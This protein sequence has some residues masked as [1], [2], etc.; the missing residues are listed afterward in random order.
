[1]SMTTTNKTPLTC[2][3][4][5]RGRL[6]PGENLAG[7]AR[8]HYKSVHPRAGHIPRVPFGDVRRGLRRVPDH[9]GHGRDQRGDEHDGAGAVTAP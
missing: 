3:V 9:G 1:M 8:Q 4:R 7:R 5:C 2:P 6:V